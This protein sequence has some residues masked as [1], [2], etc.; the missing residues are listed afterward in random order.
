MPP[1]SSPSATVEQ[2]APLVNFPSARTSWL[3]GIRV[4]T[5]GDT[6]AL[7]MAGGILAQFGAHVEH[8][9]AAGR[10]LTNPYD[11]VLVDRIEAA[12]AAAGL[13]LGDIAEYLD[14]V[15][16]TNRTVWITASAYGLAD[17]R[18]EA[19][20]SEITILAAGGI[21]GHSPGR[22]QDPPTIP[23]GS[24]GLK[25]IGNVIAMA[26]LH[27]IHKFRATGEPVHIDLSAQGSLVATGL[28]LEMGHALAGCPD[29]GGSARYGAPTGFF[30]CRDGSVYVLV[31][32]QHQWVGFRSVLG[33]VLDSIPT[34]ESAR[35][36]ADEVNAAMTAWSSTRTTDE[37]E[38]IL[39]GVGVPCTIVNTVERFI[40]R[41]SGSGRPFDPTAPEAATLPAEFS[42]SPRRRHND[43]DA[44]P[45]PL[46]ELRVLDAGHVLA[47]PLAAAWLGAMGAQVVK[48]EDPERLDIYRRRGPFAAG[49][50]GLNR[51]GYFNHLN[52]CKSSLDMRGD[53]S[54]S[55]LDAEPYDVVMTNLSPHRAKNIGV[56]SESIAA[57]GTTTMHLASSGFGLTGERAGY[58]AY[59]TTIHAFS[60]LIAATRNARGEMAGVGTPW[61]DPLASVTI[62]T[63]VLAWTLAPKRTENVSV[64]ISMAEVM[65]THLADLIGRPPEENYRP[66]AAGGD[67]FIR[68][69]EPQRFIALTLRDERDVKVFESVSGGP[70]P[71]L[72]H[73]GQAITLPEGPL[74]A[75]GE[76]QLEARLR[77]AGLRACRT[78][79]A[80]DLAADRRLHDAELFQT[81]R[82]SALGNYVT[83]GLPWRF[84][85]CAKAPLT[86]APE[87]PRDE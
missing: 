42:V 86:A 7:R 10:D 51:S 69:A 39:Q 23:A 26:A 70:L 50:Q 75:L 64:D 33:S 6:P 65:A 28:A 32:E 76:E 62:T 72:H 48:L 52:F 36:R 38:R 3:V 2:V 37:C 59:G 41:S 44:K 66:A 8:L 9:D 19:F 46:S 43:R 22:D 47:V 11:V 5:S 40:E 81:V 74:S 34:L 71:A 13:P 60:G 83:T 67:V 24:I 16:H 82:S 45:I 31:L 21:L 15:T 61:A 12:P 78:Y 79:T 30:S 1:G 53:S 80:H 4:V 84:V 73:R 17:E 14:F 85:G 58:R 25:L 20:A 35:Q 68:L 29:A 55:V 27:G 18:A 56:G 87:R 77:S 63:W 54:G 49:V 57:T